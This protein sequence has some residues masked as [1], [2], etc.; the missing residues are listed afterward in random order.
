MLTLML[1]LFQGVGLG[2]H[3]HIQVLQTESWGMGIRRGVNTRRCM[4]SKMKSVSHRGQDQAGPQLCMA[5]VGDWGP[6]PLQQICVCG[7]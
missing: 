6:S 4:H 5:P 3:G 2:Y 1:G 7:G